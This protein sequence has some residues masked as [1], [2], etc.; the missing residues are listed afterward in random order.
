MDAAMKFAGPEV[1]HVSRTPLVG[2]PGKLAFALEQHTE[3]RASVILG[4][5]YPGGL[6]GLFLDHAVVYTSSS[7]VH[8]LCADLIRRAD[9]IHVHNDLTPDLLRLVRE[10]S[11][12][13]CRFIYQ[14]HSPLREGP[15]FFD[16]TEVLGFDWRAKLTIPHSQQRFYQDYL[17]VPNVTLFASSCRPI[18]PRERVRVLF[19]PT[20]RRTGNRW[21]DKLSPALE[22]A[23]EIVRA[24]ADVEVIEV[25]GVPPAALMAL[26][27]TTHVTIDEI[28]TG[29]FHQISLEGLCA[30]NVVVNGAD[31]FARS[32]L[33]IACGI[34]EQPPFQRM[35]SDDVAHRLLE[36]VRDR[37]QLRALQLASHAYYESYLTPSRLAPVFAKVYEEALGAA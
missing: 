30:G 16:R 14:A 34:D 17:I 21:N 6:S 19:S 24:L 4:L 11:R 26:R 12:G 1:V 31:H 13:D 3:Y 8:E 20:H 33:A 22:R 9:I 5:D 35:T 10:E 15:L 7:P 36:L 27:R 32:S 29:A 18:D 25:G 2:A 28:A 37:D 23:L